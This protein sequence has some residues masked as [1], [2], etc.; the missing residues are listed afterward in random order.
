MGRGSS[1]GG[2][3]LVVAGP[4]VLVEYRETLGWQ[5]IT[6]RGQPLQGSVPDCCYSSATIAYLSLALVDC[7]LAKDAF[8]HA[9]Q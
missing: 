6:F 4:L 8:K 7:R 5:K 3:G 9:L 1:P 2:S